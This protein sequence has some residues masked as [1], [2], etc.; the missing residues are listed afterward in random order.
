ML[1]AAHADAEGNCVNCAKPAEKSESV[2]EPATS[3]HPPSDPEE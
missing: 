1:E 3:D 2:V